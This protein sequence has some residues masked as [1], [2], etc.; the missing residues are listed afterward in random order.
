MAISVSQEQLE[1][2]SES[3]ACVQVVSFKKSGICSWSA[4]A[5]RPHGEYSPVFILI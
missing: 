1:V 3:P 4:T 5:I 2:K